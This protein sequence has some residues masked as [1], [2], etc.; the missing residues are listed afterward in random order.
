MSNFFGE[1]FCCGLS[2]PGLLFFGKDKPV[3]AGCRRSF[4]PQL[5]IHKVYRRKIEFSNYNPYFHNVKRARRFFY[6]R[7]AIVFLALLIMR[8]EN[9]HDTMLKIAEC[10]GR[11]RDFKVL[12]KVYYYLIYCNFLLQIHKNKV[13]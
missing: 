12:R 6:L 10:N 5:N 11:S 1:F 3:L 7:W 13:I 4:G 2:S 8:M 9:T